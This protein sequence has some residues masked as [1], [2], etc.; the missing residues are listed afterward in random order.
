M[1]KS[2]RSGYLIIESMV[3]L[4][5]VLVG[6]LGIF[7]LLA[8]SF[9]I[10]RDLVNQVMAVNL[11]VEGVE[12]VKNMIDANF[13]A[14]LVWNAGLDSG[15][16]EFDYACQSLTASIDCARRLGSLSGNRTIV[17]GSR[18]LLFDPTTGIYS[19]EGGESTPF[20]RNIRIENLGGYEIKVNALVGWHQKNREIQTLNLEDHFF[21]WR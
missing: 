16:Y 19:Y 3:A 11:A 12:I 4:S 13:S 20:E 9:G 2:S 7:R 18:T 10:N 1:I 17:P 15:I 5:L 21:N 8:A 6:V 14:G